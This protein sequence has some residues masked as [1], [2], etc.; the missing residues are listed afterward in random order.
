[1]ASSKYQISKSME[2]YRRKS[3]I[4]RR[5]E[6]ARP[7]GTILELFSRFRRSLATGGGGFA[8]AHFCRLGQHSFNSDAQGD[9][10]SGR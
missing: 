1:M 10:I 5:R 8:L 9:V 2:G 4:V 6:V 3:L 7:R